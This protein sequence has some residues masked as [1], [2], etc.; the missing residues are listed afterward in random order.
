MAVRIA[1]ASINEYGSTK[2]GQQGDQNAKEVTIRNFY[3]KGWTYLLRC[4]NTTIASRMADIAEIGCNNNNIGY[5]QLTRNTAY[6]EARK[7]NYD[8]SKISVPCS[9]DC[10]SFVTLVAICA[11]IRQLDYT[12]NAPTTSTMVNAFM[13]TGLFDVCADPSLLTTEQY[14]VKGDILVKPGSHTVIVLD[15]GPAITML[16]YGRVNSSNTVSQSTQTVQPTT[17]LP[18]NM[19][20]GIDI[21]AYNEVQDY[22]LV[23]QSGVQFAILKIIRKDLQE[24]KLFMKHLIGC[25]SAGIPI[26][27][28]YNY[29]Y[30]TSVEKAKTDALKVIEVLK[31]Y[32]LN[33]TVYLD[34]ED[35]CQKNLGVNLVN[36]INTYQATIENAG[37]E[38]GLYTGLS[39]YK[40][41]ILPFKKYT[42]VVN[43][44]IARYPSNSEM[45]FASMPNMS[46]KPDIGVAIEGW[47]YSSKCRVNGIKGLVDVNLLFD[48]SSPI[49]KT[50]IVYNCNKLNFRSAPTTESNILSVLLKNEKVLIM[51]NLGDWYKV[52]YNGIT[53]YCSSKYIK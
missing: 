43:E 33:T 50:G 39:F 11:G 49:Y 9:V 14:L 41:Y 3:S 53:G 13:K 34:V 26:K 30:A 20:K 29:S 2:N 36:I 1:H 40:T 38:F 7:V 42:S 21:S 18:I 45:S 6:M 28:V 27:G 4:K 25:K 19:S 5:D 35:D 8:L 44:W 22:N 31:K 48:I 12:T 16:K 23:K 17:T 32:N 10:S 47:Q 51:E 52:Q 37:Y 46:K 15:D 24:D